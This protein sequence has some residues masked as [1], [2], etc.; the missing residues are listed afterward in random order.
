[1]AFPTDFA[2]NHPGQSNLSGDDHALFQKL[3]TGEVLT[4]FRNQVHMRPMVNFRTLRGRDRALFDGLG[5]ISGQRHLAH[6]NIKDSTNGILQNVRHGQT[7]IRVDRPL[8]TAI[9]IDDLEETVNH[10]DVRMPYVNQIGKFFAEKEDVEFMRLAIKASQGAQG[11]GGSAGITSD[12][13][14]GA[15]VEAASAGTS[16]SALLD[17]IQEAS[18]N[19]DTSNVPD[20]GRVCIL[21]PAQYNLLA[22]PASQ[23]TDRDFGGEGNGRLADGT[24]FKAWGM[25]LM[26]SNLLPQ[27]NSTSSGTGATSESTQGQL[28]TTYVTNARKTVALCYHPMALGAVEVFPMMVKAQWDE[29]FQSWFLISRQATGKGILRPEGAQVIRTGDPATA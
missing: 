12:H 8:M 16:A 11:A 28:G 2:G 6:T 24:V 20:D 9:G 13:P 17:A 3:I 19:F 25:T 23:L 1:M 21:K 29:D 5:T 27:D 15:H 26:K 4:V 10:Y 7:E 22:D 18:E 14:T